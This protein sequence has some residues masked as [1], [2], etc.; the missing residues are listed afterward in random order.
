MLRSDS[1]DAWADVIELDWV[2]ARF[3]WC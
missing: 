1:V 2:W 3:L